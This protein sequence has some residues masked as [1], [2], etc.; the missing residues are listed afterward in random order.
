MELLEDE[1]PAISLLS[2]SSVMTSERSLELSSVVVVVVVVVAAAAAGAS[3]V[4]ALA[5]SLSFLVVGFPL[6]IASTLS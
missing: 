6:A 5:A 4:S 3:S 2:M 1:I